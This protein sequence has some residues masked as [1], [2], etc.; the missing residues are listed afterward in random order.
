MNTQV[1]PLHGSGKKRALH[2]SRSDSVPKKL[3]GDES[4]QFSFEVEGS[5]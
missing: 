3:R 5:E 1:S 4:K 2:S